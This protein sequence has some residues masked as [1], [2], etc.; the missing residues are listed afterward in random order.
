MRLPVA[1]ALSLLLSNLA[2][3]KKKEPEDWDI[4]S[5]PR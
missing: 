1:L 3:A 5:S 4:S 2:C